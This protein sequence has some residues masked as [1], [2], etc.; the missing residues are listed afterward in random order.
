MR[1]LQS[2]DWRRT[3]L[4]LAR[5]VGHA[6]LVWL[7]L[8]LSVVVFSFAMLYTMHGRLAT[9]GLATVA[10]ALAD[11]FGL[12]LLLALSKRWFSSWWTFVVGFTLLAVW[13]FPVA[14][15]PLMLAALMLA[16]LHIGAPALLALTAFGASV[17]RR[18]ARPWVSTVVQP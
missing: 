10:L 6:A 15:I 14:G 9:V 11:F 2:I 12:W 3:A 1:L 4:L 13:V 17:L 8:A 5:G 7:H 16:P 18:R